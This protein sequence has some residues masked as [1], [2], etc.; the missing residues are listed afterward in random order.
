MIVSACLI[1]WTF[2]ASQGPQVPLLPWGPRLARGQE[3]VYRGWF[4]EETSNRGTKK[5]RLYHAENRILV[6]ETSPTGTSVALLIT[7][8][9]Q[10]KNLTNQNQADRPAVYL[11]LGRVDLRGRITLD[12][13]GPLPISQQSPPE[14]DAG[15]FIELPADKIGSA[16]AWTVT[17]PNGPHQWRLTG[18]ETVDGQLCLKLLGNQ[19]SED[20]DQAGANRVA[21]RRQDTVWLSPQMGIA[22]RYERVIE[23]RDPCSAD[24]SQRSTASFHLESSLVYPGQLFRDR[25]A[26]INL[27]HQYS[28]LAEA[29]YREPTVESPRRLG[30]LAA[31]I[32]YHCDT[33]PPTPYRAALRALQSRLELAARGDL[34]PIPAGKETR[35][36]VAHT[37]AGRTAPDF[38]ATDLTTGAAIRMQL[39]HGRPVLLL[40][41]NP[42]SASAAESLRFA[43]SIS[44]TTSVH[45][46]G[47]SVLNEADTVLKQRGDLDLTFPL[48]IGAELRSV[49]GVDATPKIVLIDEDGSIRRTFEGW[50]QETPSLVRE[51]LDRLGD[52]EAKGM[53]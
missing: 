3:L 27:F 50:G 1:A 16:T 25:Q 39:L 7:T 11:Q 26:E 32:A 10:E 41:Y 5:N 18:T 28:Q 30:A 52:R 14:I 24:S 46:L 35:P 15:C 44:Q 2:A 45:V 34:P 13:A 42:R 21:W 33:Q 20:W 22:V 4:N 17:E 53:K 29:C 6:S 37:V 40:F 9:L 8:E 47:L 43:Q 19:Q 12:S 51:E 38:V 48:V 23:G 31:K 36:V 49:F